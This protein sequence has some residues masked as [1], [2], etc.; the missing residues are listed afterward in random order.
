MIDTITSFKKDRR[1]KYL[2]ITSLVKC[3]DIKVHSLWHLYS[4]GTT[5]TKIALAIIGCTA[6]IVHII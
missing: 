5:V 3:E 1:G 4:V 6:K 2:S